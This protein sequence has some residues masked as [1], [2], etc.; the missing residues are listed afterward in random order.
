MNITSYVTSERQ[1][2]LLLGDYNV[3]RAQASRRIHSLRK[4]LGQATPKGRKYSP[5]SPITAEDVGR[6]NECVVN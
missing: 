4:R 5:K 3:Y 6:N 1:K 2:G